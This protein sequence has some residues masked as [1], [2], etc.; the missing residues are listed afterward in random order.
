[1][2]EAIFAAPGAAFA[3]LAVWLAVRLVNRQEQWAKWTAIGMGAALVLYIALVP[4]LQTAYW[5]GQAQ[6]T[7]NVSVHDANA[8]EPVPNAQVVVFGGPPETWVGMPP[9]EPNDSDYR[10]QHFSTDTTG[11]ASAQHAFFTYG[12]ENLFVESGR[13]RLGDRYVRVTASGY[14][15]I[16]F[17]LAERTGEQRNYHDKSPIELA[18]KLKPTA[19]D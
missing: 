15:P 9:I 8:N 19:K 10:T 11:K 18:I 12:H 17:R 13:V 5:C 2:S 4:A 14:E 1:M 7:L 3:A 16:Q 6:L